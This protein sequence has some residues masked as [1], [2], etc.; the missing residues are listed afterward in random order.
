M[1]AM[2]PTAADKDDDKMEIDGTDWDNKFTPIAYAV[3]FG[4]VETATILVKE[5]NANTSQVYI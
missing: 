5:G 3:F 1:E 4:H 2:D